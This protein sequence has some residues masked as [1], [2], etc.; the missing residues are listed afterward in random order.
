[1]DIYIIS[2]D[3]TPIQRLTGDPAVE[4]EVDWTAE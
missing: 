4:S 3:G 1:M 2:K